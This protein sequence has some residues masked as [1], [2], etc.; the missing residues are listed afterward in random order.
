MGRAIDV[1]PP[2]ETVVLKAPPLRDEL[3][4]S[5]VEFA[6]GDV[7]YAVPTASVRAVTLPTRL[8]VLPHLPVGVVG[9]IEHRGQ[10]SPVLDLRISFDVDPA[11]RSKRPKWLIV[12]AERRK[13]AVVADSVTGVF[14]VGPGG[15]RPVSNLETGVDPRHLIGVV[16]RNEGLTFVLQVTSFKNYTRNV[17]LTQLPTG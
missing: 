17:S 10:V 4:R 1:M 11:V 2:G 7:R 13:I 5:L 12:E 3:Y 8:T 15:L 9:V 6:V 14:A 16:H